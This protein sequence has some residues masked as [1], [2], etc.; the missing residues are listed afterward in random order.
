MSNVEGLWKDYNTYEQGTNVLIAKKMIDDKNKEYIN[1]RRATKELEVLQRTLLKNNPAVPMTGSGESKIL[2]LRVTVWILKVDE[3]KQLDAWRKYIEWE[4]ANS[5]RIE[6]KL[7]L[8][9][10]V[11]F[12]YEQVSSSFLW[13][14]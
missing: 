9:K 4:K 8:T 1:A 6:D 5:L 7:L 12:A 14:N 10:R 11:I 2:K 13:P 3:R